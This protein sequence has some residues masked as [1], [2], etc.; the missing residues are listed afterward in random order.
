MDFAAASVGVMFAGLDE[1][2]RAAE[3]D[4]ES[5]E[6]DRA[7]AAEGRKSAEKDRQADR[8]AAEADKRR[9]DSDRAAMNRFTRAIMIAAIASAFGTLYGAFHTSKPTVIPAPVVNVA[10]PP[11]PIV[12]IAPIPV[13][14]TLPISGSNRFGSV[15]K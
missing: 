6:H 8:V 5:A 7:S 13:T 10:A 15:A 12:N 1:Y 4:R 3:K 11:A 14:L 2:L 9:Q